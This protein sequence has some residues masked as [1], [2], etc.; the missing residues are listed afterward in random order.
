MAEPQT[1]LIQ[2]AAALAAECGRPDLERRLAEVRR[3]VQRPSVRVLVV[4]EPKKGKSSLL[5]GLVGAPVCAVA[6]DVT[7]VVP[8]TVR[9]GDAPRA[10]AVLAVGPD[11]GPP[12]VPGADD[13]V[14]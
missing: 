8:T 12:A 13:R 3:R 11:D 10:T 2:R 9:L 14:E 5:N 1:A 4:G 6:E 7:T